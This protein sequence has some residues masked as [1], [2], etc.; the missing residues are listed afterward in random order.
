MNLIKC[1]MSG[2][3]LI[4]QMY[5]YSQLIKPDASLYYYNKG[6][7]MFEEGNY[8]QA[9]SL[10]SYSAKLQPHR[11]TYYN[12]AL[13]K[14]NLGDTCAFC[15]NLKNAEKYGDYE[16]GVLYDN[17]CIVKR[18]V[19]FD[20]RAHSDSIFYAFFSK[21]I[22]THKIIQ[23][24]YNIKDIKS[25]EVS[26][27]VENTTDSSGNNQ[28]QIPES[29]P[30]LKKFSI[31]PV[32]TTVFTVTETEIMPSFPGGDEARLQFLWNN[33][34]YPQSAMERGI[35]GTVYVTFVI[36]KDGS[37][38]DVKVIKGIGGGCDEEAIRVVKLLPKWR[39]GYQSGKPV[40]VLFNMPIRFTLN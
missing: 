22:C 28:L 37:I 3:L 27:Y 36:D 8:K 9:D 5:S 10:F 29:F 32:D 21:S 33:I 17:K 24:E 18:K 38:D 40:R 23:R 4:M 30:D 25:G 16:S 19:N 11:D 14:F 6:L 12:L 2:L 1:I 7:K 15:D 39:P 35:Q 31:E 26:T 20:N 34:I 13:T